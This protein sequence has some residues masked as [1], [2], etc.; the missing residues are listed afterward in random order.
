M[1]TDELA[2]LERRLAGVERELQIERERNRSSRHRHER[3]DRKRI[4]LFVCGL[5]SVGAVIGVIGL[6]TGKAQNPKIVTMLE[7]PFRIVDKNKRPIMEVDED[8]RSLRIFNEEG[9]PVVTLNAMKE[10]KGGRVAVNDGKNSDG[11]VTIA[12]PAGGPH[13]VMKRNDDKPLVIA[14]DEGFVWY[15]NAGL[16]AVSLGAGESGAKGVLKIADESGTAVV[17]AGSLTGGRGIVRVYPSRGQT[18]L[19]I[20]QFLMGSKP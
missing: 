19:N 6:P 10:S 20:P 2:G 5:M 3:T 14:N 15:N 8:H 11:Y 18:P 9:Q 4:T 1:S 7:A 12:Y 13:F 17:E 16:P